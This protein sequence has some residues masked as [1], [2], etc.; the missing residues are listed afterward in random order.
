KCDMRSVNLARILTAS[1]LLF[2]ITNLLSSAQDI[3]LR[4]RP[5]HPR[6]KFVDLGTFGGPASYVNGAAA[7]GALNQI[8][9]HGT[10]VG[11]AATTIPIPTASNLTICGGIDGIAPFVIHSLHM[12]KCSLSVLTTLPGA[13]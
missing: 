9:R 4:S 1:V 5:E 2:V 8:N 7:L 3:P 13:I 11:S 6:Y 10:T 12:C